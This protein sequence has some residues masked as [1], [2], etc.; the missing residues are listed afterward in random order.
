MTENQS[1]RQYPLSYERIV[2]ITIAILALIVIGILG[3]TIA[4]AV[5]VLS[6]G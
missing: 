6:F 3:F 1:K 5:G 4:V 2:P